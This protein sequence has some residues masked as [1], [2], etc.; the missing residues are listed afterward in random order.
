MRGDPERRHR[1]SIRL[2]GYDYARA[3]AYFVT[4]CTYGGECLFGDVAGDEMR[5]NEYGEIARQAWDGLLHHY[6]GVET[7][8]FV[9]MPNHVHGII[10]ITDE[11]PIMVGAGCP[12]PY[13]G[14]K[15]ATG[16]GTAKGAETAPLPVV[17]RPTLGRILAYLKYQSTKRI[18]E[19]RGTPGTPVW[20]RNYYEHIIRDE[21]SLN[22]IRQYIVDNPARWASDPENPQAVVAEREKA[23]RG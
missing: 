13:G 15:P 6:S 17:K 23:W 5:F 2:K 20:Q 8:A 7:D 10:V 22:R 11:T 4:V 1:R 19:I 16:A 9:V 18:N 14:T 12:R 3:G 21:A